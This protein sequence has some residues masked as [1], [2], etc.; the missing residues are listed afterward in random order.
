MDDTCE[1]CTFPGGY[2]PSDTRGDYVFDPVAAARAVNFFPRY[3]TH[4]KGASAG[5]PMD[6]AGWQRNL[7]GTLFGW[8]DAAGIR[9]YRICYC[10]V[11]R[12]NGKS[13]IVAGVALLLLYLD[14][15]P[16]ADIFSAAGTRDQTKH[17][18]DV[19]KS[20]VLRSATLHKRSKVYL[21]SIVHEYN[22]LTQGAYK[23]ISAEAGYQHGGNPHGVIFDEL[24]TQPNRDLWDVLQTGTIKRRQPLTLAITTAGFDRNSI[25]YEQHKHAAKVRDGILDDKQFLPVIYAADDSDDWTD[26]T[27]WAKANPNLGVSITENALASECKRAQENPSYENTFRRLHLNQWTEQ[28]V[29]WL[30]MARWD[31][32][33]SGDPIAE[34]KEFFAKYRGKECFG[35]LDL[36]TTTDLTAFVLAFRDGANIA[37]LPFFWVPK[38]GAI[39]RSRRDRVPYLDW[40]KQGFIEATEGNVVDYDVVRKRINELQK[41][42]FIRAIARD[43]WN[44]TQITSQLQG[45]GFKMIDFGQGFR[46]MTGPAK[47][48]EKLVIA[49]Q[50]RHAGNPVLRWNAA[51][52]TVETDAAG[53]LKP[54]K[55]KSSERIDG[56]IASIMA[57][58]QLLQQRHIYRER[59][60]IT[61]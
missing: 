14:D 61:I 43:R 38:D 30:P 35:G 47:E 7:I 18:F 11:P 49:Q 51:N 16:G 41:Q 48:L 36:S 13:T 10:E 55:K 46:D 20:N 26:P 33:S 6:L 8:K 5:S 37:L 58:A 54:N 60:L 32:L 40:I 19:A 57:I 29:R 25:C 9:R 22:G 45:D 44:A 12:G 4:I 2:S 28:D 52:V 27:V 21:H 23:A 24:H 3:L 1:F 17:V 53:N 50:L 56:V 39:Q 59:G 34:R 15:E 31:S 42:F